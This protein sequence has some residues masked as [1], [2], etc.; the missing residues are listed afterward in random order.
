[1][2]DKAANTSGSCLHVLLRAC[3]ESGLSG[4]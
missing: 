1:V 2:D 3:P 4:K